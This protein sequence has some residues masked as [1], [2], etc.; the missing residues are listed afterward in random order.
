MAIVDVKKSKGLKELT[1]QEA[2]NAIEANV[3]AELSYNL[4]QAEE[5]SKHYRPQDKKAMEDIEQEALAEI[6]SQ[7]EFFGDDVEKI[8]NNLNLLLVVGC[9]AE[10]QTIGDNSTS[11]DTD[12]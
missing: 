6:K 11:T 12:G 4:A 2:E 7:L 1:V 5:F 9:D 10:S 8:Y 3:E